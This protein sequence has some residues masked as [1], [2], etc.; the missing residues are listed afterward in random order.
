MERLDPPRQDVVH[1]DVERGLVELQDVQAARHELARLLV[2]D[3]GEFHS[4]AAPIAI[5]LVGERVDDRHRT[6]YRELERLRRVG[7]RERDLVGVHGA[8]ARERPGHR[9]HLGL[10]AVGADADRHAAGEVDAVDRL[11][12]AVN[13]V[14][15]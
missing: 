10:V 3:P 12:K 15:P 14:L 7:T 13:E 2:D 8:P 9:G 1:V 11:E 5:V 6:G 4:Q